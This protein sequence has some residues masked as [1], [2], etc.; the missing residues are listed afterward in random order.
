MNGTLQVIETPKLNF[1][2]DPVKPNVN[3]T[4]TFDASA[5]IHQ[6]SGASIT[7]YKW[8]IYNPAGTVVNTTYG[9]DLVSITYNFT[10]AGNWRVILSVTDNYKITYSHERPKT[11]SYQMEATIE[12]QTGGG[13]EFP[14]EYIA[15][16]IIVIVAV[17]AI[18]AILIL[19]RRR[20]VKT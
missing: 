8:Q 11:S 3:Q 14:I 9:A 17:V 4:V 12:V 19:R 16:I 1:T 18:L 2:W 6:E 10:V 20:R 5:S 13:G 15:A 7:Q